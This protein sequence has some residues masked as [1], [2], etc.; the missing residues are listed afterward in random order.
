MKIPSLF[1][2]TPK[3]Q[4]FS[5]TPRYYDPK[6]EEMEEREA[7]IRKELEKELADKGTADAQATAD[8]ID[9]GYRARM[10]GSFQAAR[11]RS[12]DT[13][14]GN[15]VMIRLAAL[16]FVSLL[17][18]GFFQWGKVVFYSLFLVFP[19]WVWLRFI[20]RN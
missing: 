17:L 13:G 3:H 19:V 12:K 15:V 18:I 7:R 11:R 14:Q 8:A 16:L 5:Y 9:V 10:K 1:G 4:R 20:R 2:R 6:K